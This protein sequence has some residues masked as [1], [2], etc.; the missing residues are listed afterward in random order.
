MGISIGSETRLLGFKSK[1]PI[2]MILGKL[3][4]LYFYFLTYRMEVIKKTIH[5]DIL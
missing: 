3:A 4:S 1:N 2:I 5:R